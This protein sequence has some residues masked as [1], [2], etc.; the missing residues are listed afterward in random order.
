MKSPSAAVKKESAFRTPSRSQKLVLLDKRQVQPALEL[1]SAL[2][3]DAWEALNQSVLALHS[4]RG[5]RSASYEGH[6]ELYAER[7]RRAELDYRAMLGATLALLNELRDT[8]QGEVLLR[9]AL[10]KHKRFAAE[11]FSSNLQEASKLIK[12]NFPGLPSEALDLAASE[13]ATS[14]RFNLTVT[15]SNDRFSV[16]LAS[17]K[18]ATNHEFLFSPGP[19]RSLEDFFS[20]GPQRVFST[21]GLSKP[22][23]GSAGDWYTTCLSFL[24]YSREWAYR[25]ARNANELGPPHVRAGA[26]V[27]IVVAIIAAVI[28]GGFLTGYICQKNNGGTGC[29][30]AEFLIPGG[31]LVAIG[32]EGGQ[33][34]QP[35]PAV[36]TGQGLSSVPLGAFGANNS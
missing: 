8:G 2:A 25:N 10:K 15:H 6:P 7:A 12:S 36:Q 9:Q 34:A 35:G 22:L 30:L 21:S 11:D 19:R 26:L 18:S 3:L 17:G 24:A 1:D 5:L 20:T 13:V 28:G 4:Y 32:N 31:F 27:I 29:K 16:K 14:E 23:R 33:G